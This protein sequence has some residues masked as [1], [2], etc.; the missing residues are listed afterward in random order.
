[1]RIYYPDNVDL[2]TLNTFTFIGG[3]GEENFG[4]YF[5]NIEKDK[6]LIKSSGIIILIPEGSIKVYKENVVEAT[7]FVKSIIRQNQYA[8]N[9]IGG[10]SNGGPLA[11]ETAE[12]GN[13][14]KIMLINTS[15]Y[16]VGSK[17]NITNK[18][19]VI[20]TANN[21]SWRGTDSFINELYKNNIKNVTIISNNPNMSSAFGSKYL[22]I[23]PGN[24][25]ENGHTSNNLTKSHY[26]SYACD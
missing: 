22:V 11:G 5:Y 16:W 8:R 10:Y 23:N 3:V 17:K 9:S 1:M 24:A 13:Y 6:S 7:N 4:G 14:D 12:I 26:F 25:M 19:I 18:E 2:S 20:Y 15:F 21:D